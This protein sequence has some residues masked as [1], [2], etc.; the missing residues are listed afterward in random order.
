MLFTFYF[1]QKHTKQ[2]TQKALFEKAA[3][4]EIFCKRRNKAAEKPQARARG[5]IKEVDKESR[6]KEEAN[7][8]GESTG[9]AQN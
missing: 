7:E 5:W 6:T 4:L 9:R 8:R 2:D 1:Y 3:I